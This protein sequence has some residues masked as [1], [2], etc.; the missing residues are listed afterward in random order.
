MAEKF[1][2]TL[3]GLAVTHSDCVLYGLPIRD[4]GL[5]VL[6]LT[7]MCDLFYNISRRCTDVIVQALKGLQLYTNEDHM[8]A[9]NKAPADLRRRKGAEF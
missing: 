1:L 3:T 9:V 4:G 8:T 6:N 2:P 5:G 7:E